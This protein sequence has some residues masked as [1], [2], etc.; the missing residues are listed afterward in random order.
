MGR[1]LTTLQETAALSEGRHLHIKLHLLQ[2]LLVL[3][4]LR[5]PRPEETR[6]DHCLLPAP[7][8]REP[9]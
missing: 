7:L 6:Q 4:H 2:E 9:S 3:L 1:L 8:K 5:V